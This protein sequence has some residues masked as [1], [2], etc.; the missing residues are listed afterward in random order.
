LVFILAGASVNLQ[1]IQSFTEISVDV[2]WLYVALGLFV[3]SSILARF[4]KYLD[5]TKHG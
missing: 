2:R 3:A 4:L 1:D 5:Q